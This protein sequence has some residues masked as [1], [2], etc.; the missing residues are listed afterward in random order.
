MVGKVTSF[1]VARAAGVSRTTVSMVLS[2]SRTV[3]LSEETRARVLKVAAE[4][5]YMPNSAAR[6]LVRGNTETIGLILSDPSILP[7]DGFVPLLM[8]GIGEVNRAHGYH[9]LLEGLD[10]SRP[11]NPYE[12]LVTARRIDGMIV[13]NPRSDDA[14][15]ADLVGGGFPVVLVGSIRHPQEQAVN[16]AT[17]EG[18]DAAVDHLVGQ[19]HRRFGT[20][21]FS[22]PGFIATE[23]RLTALRRALARHGKS[24]DDTAVE[25]AAFSAESG[26]A[27]LSR[28]IDRRPDLTALFA[29]NDMIALGI[30]GEAHRRQ[31]SVP[32][33]LSLV[34]FD[35]LPF[36]AHLAPSL[37]TIA[38][39]AVAQGRTAAELL[40]ARLTGASADQLSRRLPARFI[41]R[42]ST[43]PARQG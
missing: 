13:L 18:I 21:P 9:V 2:G 1:D 37:S 10:R 12:R 17:A 27:A 3:A 33:H 25:H 36:A 29:G 34:G 19:G 14:D 41:A 5:G 22:P 11:G 23:I 26:A 16:F 32:D 8:Q 38:V 43:G 31:W 20:I 15:L 42:S 24:L 35:D 6:M 4:L 39:D 7:V 30:L 28:L 40:I